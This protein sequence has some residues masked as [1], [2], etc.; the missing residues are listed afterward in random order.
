MSAV[1][2]VRPPHD[3]ACCRVK[4][5]GDAQMRQQRADDTSRRRMP[6]REMPFYASSLSLNDM[7]IFISYLALFMPFSS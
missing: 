3:S 6:R 2:P 4:D 5:V 1:P 7:I